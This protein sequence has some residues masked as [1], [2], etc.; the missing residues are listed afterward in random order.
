[1]ID[2]VNFREFITTNGAILV[3][4]DYVECTEDYL[5]PSRNKRVR[6]TTKDLY[7]DRD[8]AERYLEDL[9]LDFLIE[10]IF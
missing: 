8:T 7:I 3:N 4:V 5:G 10:F 6:I 9:E 2:S 1:M